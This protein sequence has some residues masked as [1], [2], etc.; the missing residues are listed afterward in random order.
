MRKPVILTGIRANN[1]L[2]IGNY[3]GAMLPLIDMAKT[4]SDEFDINLFIPDL[5]SFTTPIDHSVLF[6][7]IMNNARVYA[8]AGL[9]LD[10]DSI[11]LYR[12]SY[13]PAHS[14]LT[15]LLN[16]FVGMG[17]MSRMTQFKDKSAKLGDSQISVGLFDYPVL[18]ASDILLYNANYVPVGDDQSQHLEITRDIAERM[19]KRFDDIFTVPEP[20]QKQHEFF[21]HEQGLRIKDL[22]DPSKKMSKSD[23]SGKGVLFLNDA[24]EEAYKKIMNATTDDKARVRYDKQA[25]PGITNLIDILALLRGQ[26]PS[27]VA[28]EYT[29]LDRYGEFKKVVAEE[30]AIFLTDFQTRLNKIDDAA[31]LSKLESSEAAMRDVANATLLRVQTAV[32]LRKAVS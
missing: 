8:A 17:E 31:I 21:G 4:R 2:H 32:G 14:E 1:D 6:D 23:E 5:H 11:H 19:N 29:D 26:Q 10:N 7:S 24:P 28:N 13:I 30:M 16:N 25:Q 27:E 15:I 20:V 3:F 9:P 22:V 12:Q 18:M